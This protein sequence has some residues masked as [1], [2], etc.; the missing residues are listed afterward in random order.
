M[1][2]C[3][4]SYRNLLCVFVSTRVVN[5]RE[6]ALKLAQDL[7]VTPSSA[8]T[9]MTTCDVT[10]AGAAASHDV[11]PAD[12]IGEQSCDAFQHACRLLMD[13]SAFPLFCSDSQRALKQSFKI[14]E[15]NCLRFRDVISTSIF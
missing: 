2:A 11:C 3:L 9:M 4:Y 5:D 13:F 7:I 14:G 8:R 12:G 6:L 10:E 15:K 1:Q